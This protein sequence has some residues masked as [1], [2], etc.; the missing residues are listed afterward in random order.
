M[1]SPAR[2]DAQNF[3]AGSVLGARHEE[4]TASLTDQEYSWS[5]VIWEL[6]EEPAYMWT[7]RS[8]VAR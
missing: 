8:A 6:L 1:N 4:Q 7:D 3:T 5:L 2:Y